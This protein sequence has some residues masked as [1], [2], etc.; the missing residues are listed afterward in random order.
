M[1]CCCCSLPS[2]KHLALMDTEY[3]FSKL[4]KVQ[5]IKCFTAAE[6]RIHSKDR[7]LPSLVDLLYTSSSDIFTKMNHFLL[8]LI[9]IYC[10]KT[11]FSWQLDTNWQQV[12]HHD[13]QTKLCLCSS[14]RDN[15]WT[16]GLQWNHCCVQH[17][18]PFSP[19]GI[20]KSKLIYNHNV[21]DYFLL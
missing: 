7:S 11:A 2:V 13:I 16:V 15:S 17:Q 8:A 9:K 21:V 19:A 4:W 14:L 1:S 12:I 3:T 10:G 20:I 18:A 6:E 5:H